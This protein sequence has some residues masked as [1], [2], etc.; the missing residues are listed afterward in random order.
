M[1]ARCGPAF[2]LWS[3]TVFFF[4]ALPSAALFWRGVSFADATSRNSA[5]PL[6]PPSPRSLNAVAARAAV[7]WAFFY[8]FLL[9]PLRGFCRFSRRRPVF[10]I[11]SFSTT[12]G[13]TVSGR[14][15]CL[16]IR[17][18]YHPLDH[19]PFDY[20]LP[21]SAFVARSPRF[22]DSMVCAGNVPF[23]SSLVGKTLSRTSYLW[24]LQR[25]LFPRRNAHLRCPSIQI[26]FRRSWNAH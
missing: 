8:L 12:S 13:R 24:L 18:F 20:D 5:G 19:G 16:S 17:E 21:T 25:S 14:E 15:S 3:S 22:G 1:F 10:S 23:G 7:P 4:S 6:L 2:Q 26:F 11:F 9:P